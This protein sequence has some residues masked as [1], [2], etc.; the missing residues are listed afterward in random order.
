MK[1]NSNDDSVT[2]LQQRFVDLLPPPHRLAR[3]S[4]LRSLG[5]GAALLTP[6]VGV[7]NG[8][9]RAATAEDASA[10][11]PINNGDAAI[12][13]FLAAAE[14]LEADLWQQYTELA[15]GNDAYKEALEAIEDENPQYIHDNTDDELSHAA[16][17][18]AYLASVGAEPVNL[19]AFRTLPS[20]Q[21]TGA[22]QI[23][24]LTN[25]MNLT[26]D[27]SWWIRY[28]SDQNPDFGATFPQLIDIVNRPAIPPFDIPSGSDQIQAIANTAAFHF[29]SIE[30]GGSSLYS[31]LVSKVS[32][33]TVLRIVTSIGGTEVFHFAIW[34]DTAGN[35]P[36]VTFQGLSFPDIEKEFE[37]DPLR[38][39]A[40]VMPE[41]C[42][43]INPNL[44][45]CSVIRPTSVPLAG[46]R[47]AVA[48]LTH[49]GLFIGQS[50]AFFQALNGLAR[51]ADGARRNC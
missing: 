18:N 22:E 37:G 4:F 44:P 50:P 16:F 42:Q 40:L 10:S 25:L 45:V 1:N 27:T 3:R 31:S 13:R 43:F 30:Q 23:G 41:P 34:E 8:V 21:A 12:L 46:A 29:A 48:A 49:S 39:K 20:S 19:D 5:I 35:V 26:V 33:L 47:A 9:A 28:R 17:L 2:D 7:I 11:A 14:L 51:A 38:D 24:R 6:A 32:N 15:D 36:A